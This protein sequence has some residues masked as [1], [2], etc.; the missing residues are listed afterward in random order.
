[1]NESCHIWMR[2]VTY[3]WVMSHMNEACHIWMNHTTYIN[4][5]CHSTC[6]TTWAVIPTLSHVTWMNGSCRHVT[7]ECG[8]SLMEN[9]SC[10]TYERVMS[11]YTL[12]WIIV[13]YDCHHPESNPRPPNLKRC[14]LKITV[15]NSTRRTTCTDF[16]LEIMSHMWMS[17]TLAPLNNAVLHWLQ[18]HS[19]IRQ[20]CLGGPG[21]Q[22]SWKLPHLTLLLSSVVTYGWGMSLW[23]MCHV[24]HMNE[25]CHST[26]GTTYLRFSFRVM[27]RI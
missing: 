25:S 1:M 14:V 27:S 2:H 15:K 9:A 16:K 5:S 23:K 8:M 17:R 22:N 10:H 18:R 24:T 3:E 7:Y 20:T 21:S 13:H 19:V 12:R 6:W 26:C 11:Q 4:E